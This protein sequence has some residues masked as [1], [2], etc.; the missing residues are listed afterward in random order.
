MARLLARRAALAYVLG[1]RAQRARTPGAGR[2]QELMTTTTKTRHFALAALL[3]TS[4]IAQQTPSDLEALC[5]RVGAAH[6]PS[7]PT[8]AVAALRCVLELQLTDVREKNGGQ[9]DLDVQFLQQPRPAPKRARSYIRYE[10]RGGEQPIRRGFDRVGPW[11]IKQGKPADLTAAGAE[12]DLASLREHI[13][14]ASQL[15]RF[16]S[17]EQVLAS[18]QDPGEVKD[19]LL[20][21]GRKQVP[22]LSVSGKLK[23]FPMV[24]GTGEG[25][26]AYVKIYVD[27]R[28]SELLGVDAWPLDEAG[29]PDRRQGERI[30]LSDL[31]ERDGLLVP[32]TLRYLFRDRAGK[33]RSRSTVK[34]ISL[35]LRP[36]LTVR[37]F[38]R[39]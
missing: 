6:R 30:L 13:N 22:V 32:R 8:P 26:A 34:I 23:S 15:L 7:G 37:D 12:Q 31:R 38:D 11:H 28:S 24:Q 16:L 19:D 20:R 2:G 5:R 39:S 33:L 21:L 27:K 14:L 9:V 3:A 4:L 18:L 25:S 29:E 35:E 17:P 36:P 1:S 10:V